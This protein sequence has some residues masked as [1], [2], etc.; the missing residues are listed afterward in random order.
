M[1]GWVG[2]VAGAVVCADEGWA[3]RFFA[4]V[5]NLP[6]GDKVGHFLLVGMLAW[7]LN[8]ALL[9]RRVSIFPR[10]V[11][12][13]GLLIA[14]IMTVE[15]VSQIWIPSRSFSLSDLAANYAGILCAGW[16]GPLYEQQ[17]P[18]TRKT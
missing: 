18:C 13:G 15:E 11:L 14:V 16:L 8:R 2:L 10:P 12:L 7:L 17:Q 3:P 5:N 4:Y 1:A 9:H 6:L